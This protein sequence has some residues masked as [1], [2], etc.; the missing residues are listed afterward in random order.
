[1]KTF[2][3]P[4]TTGMDFIPLITRQMSGIDQPLG[5]HSPS[6]KPKKKQP[7]PNDDSEDLEIK[8]PASEKVEW[9]H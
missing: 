8:K 3:I 9:K 1:M 2:D 6:G 5:A 4:T 7:L